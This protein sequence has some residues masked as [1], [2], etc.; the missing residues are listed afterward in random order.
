MDCWHYEIDKATTEAEII[1]NASD[2]LLLWVPRD[3][4]PVQLGLAEMRIESSDD[5]ERVKR[6]LG[7]PQLGKAAA[8]SNRSHLRELSSYFTHAA[9]RIGELRRGYMRPSAATTPYRPAAR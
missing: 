4:D 1:R 8:I 3:L 6:W 7:D 2:Y 5:I 9:S